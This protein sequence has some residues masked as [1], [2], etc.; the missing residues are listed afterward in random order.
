[1]VMGDDISATRIKG[2]IAE[3]IKTLVYPDRI[4]ITSARYKHTWSVKVKDDSQTGRLKVDKVVVYQYKLEE[5]R[6]LIKAVKN[7][8]SSGEWLEVD[9]NLIFQD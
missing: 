9:I 4:K 8:E 3:Y 2:G 1:M 5:E 7:K 6:L